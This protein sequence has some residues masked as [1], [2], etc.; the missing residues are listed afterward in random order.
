MPTELPPDSPTALPKLWT[1]QPNRVTISSVALSLPHAGATELLE[2]NKQQRHTMSSFGES[3]IWALS[4]GKKVLIPFLDIRGAGLYVP[5]R[6]PACAHCDACLSHYKVFSA[7][8]GIST[9]KVNLDQVPAKSRKPTAPHPAQ[10]HTGQMHSDLSG[11][12][13]S[14]PHN[15]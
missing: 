6:I 14:L 9:S 2:R 10:Q 15:G 4:I 8:H 12:A 5:P 1:A 7:Q 11:T 3:F 13:P